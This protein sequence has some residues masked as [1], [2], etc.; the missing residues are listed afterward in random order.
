MRWIPGKNGTLEALAV[1][2]INGK[3][4][5]EI[6]ATMHPDGKPEF[7]GTQ[8]ANQIA[9]EAMGS[10]AGTALPVQSGAE[11]GAENGAESQPISNG[12]VEDFLKAK[13]SS[14]T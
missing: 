11:N 3:E 1:G 12:M 7:A 6:V 10:D 2:S 4:R 9:N 5:R 8:V 14:A 13:Y